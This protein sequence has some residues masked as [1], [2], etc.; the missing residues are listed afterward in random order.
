MPSSTTFQC[1]RCQTDDHHYTKCP[2]ASCD[3]NCA[4][5]MG[6]WFWR[7]SEPCSTCGKAGHA[8]PRCMNDG[9]KPVG[10]SNIKCYNCKEMGHT[11]GE[12]TKPCGERECGSTEHTSYTCPMRIARQKRGDPPPHLAAYD[13]YK[14][15]NMGH[16][17]AGCVLL[18]K[19]CKVVMQGHQARYCPKRVKAAEKPQTSQKAGNEPAPTTPPKEEEDAPAV[20]AAD[21]VSPSKVQGTPAVPPPRP[22]KRKRPAAL[23][24]PVKKRRG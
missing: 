1:R 10:A 3:N 21:A 14:C 11:A 16:F 24:T 23:V 13:C 17:A 5:P 22:S 18:C 19:W 2:N 15:G 4:N 12:C 8:A 6:H 7:C 20:A 9:T